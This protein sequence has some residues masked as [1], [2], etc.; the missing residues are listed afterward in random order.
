VYQAGTLSGNPLATAA[1][2]AVLER[3]DDAA[4]ATLTARASRFADGLAKVLPDAQ[5]TQVVT[6]TGVFF[7]P[8]PVTDYGGAQQADHQAYARFFHAMLD[9]GIFL[10]PSGYETLFVSLAHTDELIDQT[11]DAVAAYD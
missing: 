4:Y 10:A 1:G 5:V 6:L 7:C 11:I 3:L 2:L 8:T 9:A